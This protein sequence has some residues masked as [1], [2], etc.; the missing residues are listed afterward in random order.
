MPLA[1]GS[2][3]P[4]TTD[5]NTPLAISAAPQLGQC[6]R[7]GENQSLQILQRISLAF[8][9]SPLNARSSIRLVMMHIPFHT[10]SSTSRPCSYYYC[11]LSLYI[12]CVNRTNYHS[13]YDTHT[14]YTLHTILMPRHYMQEGYRV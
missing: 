4:L 3:F 12:R 11:Y 10:I 8:M 2:S 9:P 14:R 7:N 5:T 1:I 6:D 13:Q